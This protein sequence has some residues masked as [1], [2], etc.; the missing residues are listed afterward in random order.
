MTAP[1]EIRYLARVYRDRVEGYR[2]SIETFE[3][4]LDEYRRKLTSS[5]RILDEIERE[6]PEL[7]E[8]LRDNAI[9]N[10]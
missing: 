6:Y 8:E 4:L 10:R 3:G 5:E 9:I 2:H 7:K 1:E